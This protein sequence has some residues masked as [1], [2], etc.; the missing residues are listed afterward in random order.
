M[1]EACISIIKGLPPTNTVDNLDRLVNLKPELEA[2]L[3][4]AIDVPSKVLVC[5][6]T[7]REFLATDYNYNP[8][9]KLYR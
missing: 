7:S 8:E 3:R 4:N 9:T 5:N 1:L 2:E 6:Q